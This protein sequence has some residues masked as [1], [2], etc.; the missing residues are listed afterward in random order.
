LALGNEGSQLKLS[1]GE[2]VARQKTCEAFQGLVAM[3]CSVLLSAAHPPSGICC[4]RRPAECAIEP[5]APCRRSIVALSVVR[6]PELAAAQRSGASGLQL[7]LQLV[8]LDAAVD[9]S[10][11]RPV[12]WTNAHCM[13]PHASCT[14]RGQPAQ[15]TRHTQ[16]RTRKTFHPHGTRYSES[17]DLSDLSTP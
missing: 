6:R 8:C 17:F 13:T 4:P 15:R 16:A 5:G 1:V 14:L 3:S 2:L 7:Q 10:K 9:S 11:S 12:G